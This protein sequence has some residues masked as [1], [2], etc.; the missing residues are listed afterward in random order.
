ML[1]RWPA[2]SLFFKNPPGCLF[3]GPHLHLYF[4]ETLYS[5][6]SCY[7]KCTRS[8]E[9]TPDLFSAYFANNVGTC[10]TAP[11]N[12]FSVN[13]SIF[14]CSENGSLC[15]KMFVIPKQKKI[16][17]RSIE[18]QNCVIVQK[19]MDLTAVHVWQKIRKRRINLPTRQCYWVTVLVTVRGSEPKLT[20]W[21]KLTS[22]SATQHQQVADGLTQQLDSRMWLT[23]QWKLMKADMKS[24]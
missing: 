10:L 8:L 4:F 15:V 20:C 19:F 13:C 2:H 12:C 24:D 17:V 1:L 9:S 6:N 16:I 7:C 5:N 14:L 21:M 3:D 23:N 18:R 11:W 22:H